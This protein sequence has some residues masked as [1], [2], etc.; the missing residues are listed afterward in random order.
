VERVAET[1][2]VV[3]LV[4]VAAALLRPRQEPV[5]NEVGDDLLGG[6]LTDSHASRHLADPDRGLSGD[7]KKHVAVVREQG[8]LR[9]SGLINR[10]SWNHGS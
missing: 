10:G 7:A 3:D 1:G 8:P 5:V 9:A 6:A 2:V 4:S